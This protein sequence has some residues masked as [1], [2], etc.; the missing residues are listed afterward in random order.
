MKQT[1]YERSPINFTSQLSCPVIFFQGLED[2]VV[3]PNQAEEMYKILLEKNLPT[4]YI[5]YEGEQHGFKKAENIKHSLECE[6]YFYSKIFNLTPADKLPK[7][8][9]KNLD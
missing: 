9:I 2:R 1:Y 6:L 3:P 4:A 7:I 5:P 8:E